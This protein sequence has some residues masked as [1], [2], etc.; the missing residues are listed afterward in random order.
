MNNIT[1][2]I[3]QDLLTEARMNTVEPFKNLYITKLPSVET[4]YGYEVK[5]GTIILKYEACE[6]TRERF[7]ETS[8]L[9]DL[10]PTTYG[11][12]LKIH[13]AN[14]L[15]VG[16]GSYAVD[17]IV[18]SPDGAYKTVLNAEGRPEIHPL[19]GDVFIKVEGVGYTSVLDH[20]ICDIYKQYVYLD[21]GVFIPNEFL[22][23]YET[24]SGTWL[25]APMSCLFNDPIVAE[26]FHKNIPVSAW[27]EK[28]EFFDIHFGSQV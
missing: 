21:H 6:D 10:L 8:D 17:V 3:S 26:S 20:V 16:V 18:N 25:Y 5:D 23:R 28:R 2:I 11:V 14:R 4:E 15:K 9:G 7:T 22:V 19:Q 12:L 13:Q 24:S 27:K 1:F